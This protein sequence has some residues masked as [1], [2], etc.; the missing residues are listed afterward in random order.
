M[1]PGRRNVLPWASASWSLEQ[2]KA[3]SCFT[4]A[5][6]LGKE[7]AVALCLLSQALILE[8]ALFLKL[9]AGGISNKNV[10]SLLFNT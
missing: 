4:S 5:R 9:W 1:A 6:F 8:T 10:W 3:V 2:S 7:R